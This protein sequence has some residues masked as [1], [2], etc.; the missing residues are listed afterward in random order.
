VAALFLAFALLAAVLAG[1]GAKPDARAANGSEGGQKAGQPAGTG[2][3]Q[4]Q[5][6][7][8][9]TLYFSDKQAM[10]LVPE[11]RQVVLDKG[12][13]EE[14]VVRELI[15]GTRNPELNNT[16]PE[17]TELLSISIKDGTALVDFSKEFQLKHS[18][19]SAGESMTIYSVVNSLAELKGIDKVQ[20]LLEGQKHESIL[21]HID[22]SVPVEPDWS[23]VAK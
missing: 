5:K 11:E 1:C 21:G 12:P 7:E 14:A 9:V 2:T 13:V 20:F 16:I 6:I 3:G 8:L 15:A 10:S 18:K 4:E 23:I 22:T 19:G 17:G